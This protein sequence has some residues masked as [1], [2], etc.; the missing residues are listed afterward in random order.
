MADLNRKANRPSTDSIE[1]FD[2]NRIPDHDYEFIL[3]KDLDAFAA[4][5]RTPDSTSSPAG[6]DGSDRINNEC[7]GHQTLVSTSTIQIKKASKLKKALFFSAKRD[8]APARPLKSGS[9]SK[10]KN[11]QKYRKPP[12]YSSDETREGNAYKLLKW[13]LLVIVSVLMLILAICYL[14]T[15]LYIWL[16]E[17]FVAWRGMRQNLRRTLRSTTCY[18]DWVEAAKKLDSYLGNDQWKVKDAYAY[19]DHKTVKRVLEQMR[20]CRYRIDGIN[21]KNG[22]DTKPETAVE[23]LKSLIGACVKNNFVG[24]ENSR[25]YSE[26]YY[27]SKNL[28]QDFIEEGTSASLL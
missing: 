26:T 13:P 10:K 16:Y 9:R 20:R 28:V 1:N 2:V 17:Y 27:G 18:S 23:E 5:L 8:W 14:L 21:T 15:R 11:A 24:V 25:L 22:M 6:E 12:P 7:E 3:K 4:A 19:Y